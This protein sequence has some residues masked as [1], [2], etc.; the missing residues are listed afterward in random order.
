[1]YLTYSLVLT[2]NIYSEMY[3]FLNITYMRFFSA[4]M[5]ILVSLVLNSIHNFIM[6]KKSKEAN[7]FFN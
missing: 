2:Y 4:G 3:Y 1:M 6:Q 5:Y 7:L